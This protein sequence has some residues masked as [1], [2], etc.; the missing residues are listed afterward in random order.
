MGGPP[1]EEKRS[2]GAGIGKSTP[3]SPAERPRACPHQLDLHTPTSNPWHANSLNLMREHLENLWTPRP[4]PLKTHRLRTL[5]RELLR[6][7]PF[8]RCTQ[9]ALM[10]VGMEKS[11]IAHL[12]SKRCPSSLANNLLRC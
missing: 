6:F 11:L 3:A 5:V 8:K 2:E 10:P 4:R 1:L 12:Y 9:S 7:I